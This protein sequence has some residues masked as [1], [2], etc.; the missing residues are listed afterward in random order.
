MVKLCCVYQM[1]KR[2][3][4]Y[5]QIIAT[6]RFFNLCYIVNKF[7]DTGNKIEPKKTN[8]HIYYISCYIAIISTN[9]CTNYIRQV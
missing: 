8:I 6:A 3:I 7:S 5:Q 1:L 4:F 2:D 9:I